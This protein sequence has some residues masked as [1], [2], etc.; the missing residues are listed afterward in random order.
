MTNPAQRAAGANPKAWRYDQPENSRKNPAVVKLAYA[1]NQE[2][3]KA[4]SKWIAHFIITS[5]REIRPANWN[6]SI[7]FSKLKGSTQQAVYNLAKH[8]QVTAFVSAVGA[9]NGN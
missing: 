2:T 5:A 8:R 3:K 7:D 1:G 4:C 9:V 6:C